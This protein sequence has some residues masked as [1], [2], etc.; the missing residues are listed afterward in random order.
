M[1]ERE[2]LL[3]SSR[4]ERL[5]HEFDILVG[6]RQCQQLLLGKEGILE[7]GGGRP[8]NKCAVRFFSMSCWQGGD[9]QWLSTPTPS[10]EV[11]DTKDNFHSHRTFRKSTMERLCFCSFAKYEVLC[12]HS[13]HHFTQGAGDKPRIRCYSWQRVGGHLAVGGCEQPLDGNPLFA[14]INPP[15]TWSGRGQETH[16][17]EMLDRFRVGFRSN[18]SDLPDLASRL[19]NSHLYPFDHYAPGVGGLVQQP[20]QSVSD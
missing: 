1:H 6:P 17:Y 20:L 9:L 4:E 7:V 11:I 15:D 16:E 10:E 3:Y 13:S 18:E 12:V 2:G 14:K 19:A 8:G 5:G